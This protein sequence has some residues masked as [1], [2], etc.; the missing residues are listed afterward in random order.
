MTIEHKHFNEEPTN[1]TH[2]PNFKY[3]MNL[4]ASLDLK[5]YIRISDGD[6]SREDAAK[7]RRWVIQTKWETD[8]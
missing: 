1:A 4:A 3:S 5:E 8:N 6:G 7:R 2:N